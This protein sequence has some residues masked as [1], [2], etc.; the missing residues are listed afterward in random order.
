MR[1]VNSVIFLSRIS[2]F[3]LALFDTAGDLPVVL[4]AGVILSG[5]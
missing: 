2:H 3:C 5:V 1:I 4:G